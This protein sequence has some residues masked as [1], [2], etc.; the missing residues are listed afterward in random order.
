[1]VNALPTNSDISLCASGAG[2]GRERGRGEG[3][4]KGGGERAALGTFYNGCLGRRAVDIPIK[5]SHYVRNKQ[6]LISNI[7]LCASVV[8]T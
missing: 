4:R 5:V 3:A 1:M 6:T 7:Y 2:G 8:Q